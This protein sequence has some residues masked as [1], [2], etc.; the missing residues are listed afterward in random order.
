[1]E[2]V[3]SNG[4]GD[5]DFVEITGAQLTGDFIHVEGKDEKDGGIIIYPVLSASEMANFDK[6][7]KPTARVIAWT[8]TFEWD[9]LEEKSCAPKGKSTIKGVVREIEPERD[10]SQDLEIKR[11]EPAIFIEA[12]REPAPW[13]WH[14][15][16]MVLTGGGVLLLE[17]RRLRRNQ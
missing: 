4:L 1:M 9:C 16:L 7:L 8:D 15:L 17:L 13:Y 5:S 11:S 14:F 2:E 10:Q 3:A 6:G 12:G